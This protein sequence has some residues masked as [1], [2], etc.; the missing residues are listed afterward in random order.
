MPMAGTAT[1][2]TS[3]TSTPTQPSAI[4][5]PL[6]IVVRPPSP[7][8]PAPADEFQILLRRGRGGSPD[9]VERD[10]EERIEPPVLV[11]EVPPFVGLDREALA[12][13]GRPQEVAVGALFR[14]AARV[15]RIR[16][17][18]HLV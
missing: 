12:L 18:R 8:T 16:A 9:P 11:V 13:H 3:S 6:P 14:R 15:A 10:V 2:S 4:I 17:R 7:G 5:A 1:T